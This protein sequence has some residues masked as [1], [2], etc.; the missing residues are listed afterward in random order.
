MAG[1][2]AFELTQQGL[3]LRQRAI[4]EGLSV[5]FTKGA[6]GEGRPAQGEEIRLLEDLITP[7]LDVPI[8]ESL[9][10][11]VNHIMTIVIDNTE[12]QQDLLMT[13]IG[14]YAKLVNSETGEEVIPEIL[15]GYTFT[16]GYDYIPVAT[17]HFIH[18]EI[19][20]NTVLSQDGTFEIV[21]DKSR[22]YVTR[23]EF[24]IAMRGLEN[25]LN[26]ARLKLS[27]EIDSDS[28]VNDG[29]ASTPLALKTVKEMLGGKIEE[30]ENS[31]SVDSIL[32]DTTWLKDRHTNVLTTTRATNLDLIPTI[33]TNAS[34]LNTRLTAQRGTNL[35]TIPTT[36][37]TVN[38]ISTN[39]NTTN[40]RIGVS[41][42]A[43]TAN[44]VFGRLNRIDTNSGLPTTTTSNL[45]GFNANGTFTVPTG[46]TR[47]FVTAS[48]GGGGGGGGSASTVGSERGGG[49]GAGQFIVRHTFAVTPGTNISITRG[50]GGT[51]GGGS[52]SGAAGGN[53]VIGTLVTLLGG[54]GGGSRTSGGGGGSGGSTGFGFQ[55]NGEQ[56]G[57][58]SASGRGAI[59]PVG[60][61][62]G[63]GAAPN[64]TT[65]AGS[66][67][68]VVI[69]W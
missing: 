60:V 49:G 7:V 39:L 14:I 52:G 22:V 20:F 55:L 61:F 48:G 41:T 12:L 21:F 54:G 67:G 31:E 28:G 63:N 35:D 23:E 37:S 6:V 50:A 34:N 45:R 2:N 62:G 15:Y 19:S 56:G 44:T 9:A 47:I 27:D 17:I 8:K 53:T 42:D 24:D 51:G 38:S 59:N 68:F 64:G 25:R 11:H 5:H 58:I 30:L 69:E 3:E 13:E 32:A 33:N 66:P 43:T 16:D 18:R 26:D 46:V 40:S 4:A 65:T 1:Y 10:E 57:N 36:N 29:V